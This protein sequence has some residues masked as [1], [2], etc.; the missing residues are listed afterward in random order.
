[1]CVGGGQWAL[2]Q[3]G[4]GRGRGGGVLWQGIGGQGG[5]YYGSEGVRFTTSLFDTTIYILIAQIMILI[6]FILITT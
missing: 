2:G 3:G 6:Y 4:G 1:M 5:G